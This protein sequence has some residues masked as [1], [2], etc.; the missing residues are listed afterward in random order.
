MKKVINHQEE[1]ERCA[2]KNFWKVKLGDRRRTERLV[3]IAEAM[4][5]NPG[6]SIPQMFSKTYDVKATYIADCG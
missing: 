6:A 4:A 3:K 2:E 5:E 1:V